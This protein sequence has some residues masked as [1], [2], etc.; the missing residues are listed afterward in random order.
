MNNA[1]CTYCGELN[2]RQGPNCPLWC[3]HR[4]ERGIPIVRFNANQRQT[5]PPANQQNR[6]AQ[7]NVVIV[8]EQEVLPTITDQMQNVKDL[9][10][11]HVECDCLECQQEGEILDEPAAVLA[12]T[13]S[14]KQYQK[15][16]KVKDGIFK[17]PTIWEDQRKVRMGCL[18]E[19]Q[20]QQSQENSE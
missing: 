19:I 6:P 12:V 4:N 11:L 18:K 7:A 1:P 3:K 13:R 14:G 15:D 8:E 16:Q 9:R 17:D 2:H 5:G 10:V 20:K